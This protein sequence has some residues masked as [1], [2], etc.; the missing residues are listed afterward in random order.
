MQTRTLLA[1]RETTQLLAK[2]GLIYSMMA[3][4]GPRLETPITACDAVRAGVTVSRLAQAGLGNAVRWPDRRD[5]N[6]PVAGSTEREASFAGVSVSFRQRRPIAA[7]ALLVGAAVFLAGCETSPAAK[8]RLQMREERFARTVDTWAR[9]EAGRPAKVERDIAFVEQNLERQA[10]RLERAIHW[11]E[12]W[13][14]RDVKRFRDR[15]PL[16]LDKAGK[17][18]W[19]KPEGLEPT[20]ITMFF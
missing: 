2:N 9:S 17:I 7:A 12:T 5:L 20:A 19:G 3:C 16:Y 18:M 14:A 11:V 8:R 13:P 15:G 10:V 6:R 1:K 4:R